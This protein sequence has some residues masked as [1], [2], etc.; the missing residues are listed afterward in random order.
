MEIFLD[1]FVKTFRKPIIFVIDNAVWHK[2]PKEY[3]NNV[4]A[5]IFTRLNPV[6]R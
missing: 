5:V 4:L 3:K 1:E 2:D 6:E